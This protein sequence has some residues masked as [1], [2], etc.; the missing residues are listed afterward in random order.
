MNDYSDIIFLMASMVMLALITTNTIRT[1]ATTNDS[2]VRSELEYRMMAAAQD[3][4]D[5]VR[6]VDS[7]DELNSSHSSYVFSSYPLTKTISFG[8]SDQYSDQVTVT[9]SAALVEDNST[10]E[11]YEITVTASST[12]LTPSV[13]AT[14]NYIKSF[15]K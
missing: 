12:Y 14:L 3:E 15:K 6:W 5:N 10:M 1:Y 9:A 13:T 11:R 7:S 2:L 4:I 8:S